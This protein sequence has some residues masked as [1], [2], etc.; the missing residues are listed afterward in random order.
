MKDVEQVLEEGLADAYR[1]M[2]PSQQQKFRKEG[3]EAART[4]SEMVRQAKVRAREV[5]ALLT[6]WLKII[7]GVNRFFIDQE[8]KLK[9]DKIVQLAAKNKIP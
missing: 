2:N 5:L 9:T 6:K 8:A 3:D 7:P 1:K 4:I